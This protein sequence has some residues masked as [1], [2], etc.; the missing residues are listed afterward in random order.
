MVSRVRWSVGGGGVRRSDD[1]EPWRSLQVEAWR[2]LGR[3]LRVEPRRSLAAEPS[4]GAWASLEAK[5]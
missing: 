1:V 4:G 3:S 5:P 2:N